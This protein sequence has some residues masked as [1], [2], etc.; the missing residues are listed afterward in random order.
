MSVYDDITLIECNR[1]NDPSIRLNDDNN[2]TISSNHEWSTA[3]QENMLLN[4]GDR[5]LIEQ[6]AINS[7]GNGTEQIEF[8]GFADNIQVAD[9]LTKLE[10]AYY[11]NNNHQFIMPLPKRDACVRSLFHTFRWKILQLSSGTD[12]TLKFE[13]AENTM[14]SCFTRYYGSPFLSKLLAEVAGDSPFKFD[15]CYKS[16]YPV[17]NIENT[18]LNNVK[19]VAPSF[20]RFY[21]GKDNLSSIYDNEDKLID[22]VQFSSKWDF[23]TTET[24]FKIDRGFRTPQM[25]ASKL[26]NQLH[27]LSVYKD[28]ITDDNEFTP[29]Y[30]SNEVNSQDFD[31]N[32]FT[33][34]TTDSVSKLIPT[35]SFTDNYMKNKYFP[36]KTDKLFFTNTADYN[37]TLARLYG[38]THLSTNKP[39]RL[40]AACE[41]TQG[42]IESKGFTLANLTGLTRIIDDAFI[43]KFNYYSGYRDGF[44]L[45]ENGNIGCGIVIAD[46]LKSKLNDN[47]TENIRTTPSGNFLQPT[48]ATNKLKQDLF[49]EFVGNSAATPT[50]FTAWG[51]TSLTDASAIQYLD[52]SEGDLIFT[53]LVANENN[54]KNIKNAFDLIKKPN[55]DETEPALYNNNDDN[56]KKQLI[57]LLDISSIQDDTVANSR[58]K[59]FMNYN[60]VDVIGVSGIGGDFV[61]LLPPP[62]Q[63]SIESDV[64]AGT[65]LKLLEQN[66]FNNLN[67]VF[68]VFPSTLGSIQAQPH[69]QPPVGAGTGI[70]ENGTNSYAINFN[71]F[72]DINTN[73]YK[74]L[75]CSYPRTTLQKNQAFHSSGETF[76]LNQTGLDEREGY[77]VKVRTDWTPDLDPQLVDMTSKLAGTNESYKATADVLLDQT[78]TGKE[79]ESL[80]T[81]RDSSGE[82]FDI[83]KYGPNSIKSLGIGIVVGYRKTLI[84]GLIKSYRN[85]G[86]NNTLISANFEAR[87]VELKKATAT[88]DFPVVPYI[89]P[90]FANGSNFD[91]LISDNLQ[92]PLQIQAENL[93][94]L[95]Q[96]INDEFG[97]EII[98]EFTTPQIVYD[99]LWFNQY[100][101]NEYFPIEYD[102]YGGIGKIRPVGDPQPVY[103]LLKVVTATSNPNIPASHPSSVTSHFNHILNFNDMR[104]RYDVI[105]MVIKKVDQ[106]SK[107]IRIGSLRLV[108]YNGGIND[109]NA[110][111]TLGNEPAILKDVPFIAFVY[112]GNRDKNLKI[113]TPMIFEKFGISKSFGDIQ[114]SLITTTQKRKAKA[115]T[116]LINNNRFYDTVDKKF[117]AY[118][119]YIN[120]GASLSQFKYN[121]DTQKININ[122]LHT[123][124]YSGQTQYN[125][126]DNIDETALTPP[127]TANPA[128]NP[129]PE[130]IQQ[131]SRF[132]E[133][134]FYYRSGPAD[135]K[136]EEPPNLLV[137]KP[138]G[139]SLPYGLISSQTG[140]GIKSL[141]VGFKKELDNIDT[142]YLKLDRTNYKL[143][144]NGSL[145][146]KL[147]FNFQQLIPFYNNNSIVY[148]RSHQNKYLDNYNTEYSKYRNMLSPITTNGIVASSNNVGLC[149]NQTGL[150]L[151]LLGNPSRFQSSIAQVED[152]VESVNLPVKLS[153]PYL[154]VKSNIIQNNRSYIDGTGSYTNGIGVIGRQYSSNDYFYSF[155]NDWEYVVDK[156]YIL[157]NINVGI[158]TSTGLPAPIDNNSS[159]IFK[160]IKSKEFFTEEELLKK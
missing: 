98:Y 113:P 8:S 123:P 51:T 151:F 73:N 118:S 103:D 160:I 55:E 89:Y 47:P 76:F 21:V 107:Q 124:I 35:G 153:Y 93:E 122:N 132:D 62:F 7:I 16:H 26:T 139:T 90:T 79:K 143:F 131:R 82:F 4:R 37:T 150:P 14:T 66:R 69:N 53:N 22:G 136:Q 158:Y 148:S 33:F 100:P 46:F 75:Y 70:L 91:N 137:V 128:P 77:K 64:V 3:L 155:A 23:K 130:T 145:F 133:G 27:E 78:L 110:L 116:L 67:Y 36:T 88:G 17:E 25:V 106:D 65:D 117:T 19:N 111:S 72:T 2:N 129:S 31:I 92:N 86:I 32:N 141:S 1:L 80:F 144:Y 5:I 138:R 74:S 61:N 40:K 99:I 9:N 59:F 121:V 156:P 135:A 30:L 83:N 114:Q 157:S 96:P 38:S 15:F 81:L 109:G 146:S 48:V 159:I 115:E 29:P 101:E 147:G 125:F 42:I 49:N 108:V 58:N 34:N 63:Q 104:Q 13:N 50:G 68:N 126:N 57:A 20:D 120:I 45:T 97:L 12:N 41:L 10:F 87:Y 154:V 85:H 149:N 71:N 94:G 102:I 56:Y 60:E 44:I 105:K 152:F 54:F 127:A 119:T 134:I 11:V 95:L 142:N 28:F 52:L 24:E 18:V 84:N 39:F 6:V 112:K 43:E 140:I